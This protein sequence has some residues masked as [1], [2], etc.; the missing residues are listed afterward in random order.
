MTD[1]LKDPLHE[2]VSQFKKVRIVRAPSRQGLI[3]A[4]LLGYR[5]ASG[6]VLVF[7]DSHI[8]CAVGMYSTHHIGILC[9]QCNYLPIKI[10]TI[11]KLLVNFS[12]CFEN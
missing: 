1:H 9:E 3:R 4:R 11:I 2:F 6:D 7:L 10:T 12:S 8:E 5:A